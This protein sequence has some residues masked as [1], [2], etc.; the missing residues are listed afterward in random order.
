MFRQRCCRRLHIVLLGGQPALQQRIVKADATL[1]KQSGNFALVPAQE[2][3]QS[4]Q[5]PVI[6]THM[7]GAWMDHVQAVVC[8]HRDSQLDWIELD[9]AQAVG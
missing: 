4:V 5:S 2:A 9:L 8:G 1:G 7:S 3:A 6:P